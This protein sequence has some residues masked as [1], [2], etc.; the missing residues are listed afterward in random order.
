MK[1]S[2][3][4]NGVAPAS[5]IAQNELV[6][7]SISEG[8]N[9]IILSYGEA[10]FSMPDI[11]FSSLD[12][13]KG[14]HYSE[15]QGLPEFREEVANFHNIS[16]N[17]NI[18]KSDIVI[19]AGSKIL[20]Y[21]SCLA[22]LDKGDKVL[23]HEPAWVSYQEHARL[24]GASVEFMPYG[25][26][27]NDLEAYLDKYA[28]IKMF[29]LNNPNNPRG[30][31]YTEDEI[32]SAASICLKRDIFILVDESYSDFCE[33]GEFFSAGSL[34]NDHDNVIVLNS[35]SKNF[36]LSGWRIGFAIGSEQFVH[37]V[38]KFNQHLIT[39]A[40]TILQMA[41]VGKLASLQKEAKPE[42]KQLLIRRDEVITILK[43][44]DIPFLSGA[45]TFYIFIDVSEWITNT[46]DFCI[47]LLKDHNISV[48][49]GG[50]YGESTNSFLR[51]SFGVESIERIREGINIMIRELKNEK[52]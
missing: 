46:K 37:E 30:Y 2:E 18:S 23:L 29:V 52:I 41:L 44:Y 8:K 38:N 10:P 21:L 7:K 3:R 48:I 15:S 35:I 31:I 5:S 19:S 45:A 16:Y 50:A 24:A 12:H 34:V 43:E 40:P 28:N 25:A 51:I 20:S 26:E 4:T 9:P 33:K 39:C 11:D 32:R 14:A 27:I 1:F 42:I 13:N 36:G 6:Y 49:P 22:C 17:T 47:K